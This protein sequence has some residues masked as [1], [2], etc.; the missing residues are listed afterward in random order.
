MATC[1]RRTNTRRLSRGVELWVEADGAVARGH[2]THQ[3]WL[4]GIVGLH[5]GRDGW[6]DGVDLSYTW[7][8]RGNRGQLPGP[9]V[10]EIMLTKHMGHPEDVGNRTNDEGA[11]P[12]RYLGY[13]MQSTIGW[14]IIWGV[15]EIGVPPNHPF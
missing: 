15:P 10:A 13:P 11:Q 12:Y 8:F 2:Q 14:D 6:M 9:R 7:Q 5:L 4:V 3:G 1:I